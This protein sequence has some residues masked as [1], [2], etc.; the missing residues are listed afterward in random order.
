VISLFPPALFVA[1]CVCAFLGIDPPGGGPNPGLDETL[2]LWT[3]YLSVGWAGMG[4]GLA[5]T[6]L[7]RHTSKSIG[8]QT[9]GFQYEIGFSDLATGVAAFWAVHQG[10]PDAW[11]AVAIASGLFRVLAGFNHIVGMVRD[12]NFAPGNSLILVANFGPPI[13]FAIT[14][15]SL[16]V[17]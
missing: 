17:F 11:A 13:V 7:A 8:W 6:V 2:L 1:A 14:L 10:T 12:K 9:N 5:H 4:A 16:G 15:H 3:L